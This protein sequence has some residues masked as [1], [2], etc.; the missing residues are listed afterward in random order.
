MTTIL[1]INAYHGDVSAV[2]VRDGELVAAV[3]EERY[4]R[5][6]HVAGF[7]TRA[8]QACL[9]MAGVRAQEVDHVAVSRDPKAHLWRKGLF[10]LRHRP[11]GGL[12]SDRAANYRRVGAIPTTVVEAL[13]LSSTDRRPTM[14]WV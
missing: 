8:I 13:G 5:I 1:G 3:E 7:P 9:E 10:A 11:G 12:V 14:H 2:L 4:R 6:K